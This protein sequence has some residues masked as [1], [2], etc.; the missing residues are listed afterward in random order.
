MHMTLGLYDIGSCLAIT[1]TYGV[2]IERAM[3]SSFAGVLVTERT[4][5][6]V[7]M[8]RG[9][10]TIRDCLGFLVSTVFRHDVRA[11]FDASD[12]EGSQT[13]KRLTYCECIPKQA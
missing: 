6:G 8:L 3:I 13:I 1:F 10:S 11:E 7:V 2:Y 9:T 4:A 12:F 5:H